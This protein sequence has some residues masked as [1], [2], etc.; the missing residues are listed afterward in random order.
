MIH[1]DDTMKET[2]VK[3]N[4]FGGKLPVLIGSFLCLL[5]TAVILAFFATGSGNVAQSGQT[6]AVDYQITK[7]YDLYMNRTISDALDGVLPIKK[8]YWLSDYDLVAPEPNQDCFGETDDPA[9][10]QWLL[11]ESQELMDGQQTLFSTDLEISPKSKVYYYLDETIMVITWKQLVDGSMYT[12]SEVKIA[13]P[14]QLR[15]FLAD[16]EYGSSKKYYPSEM[17]PAVNAVTAL[18]GDYYAF[19]DMGIV[20]Y[21]GQVYRTEGQRL[22]SCFIDTNGDMHFVHVN[23][24]NDPA[25]IEAFVKEKNIRFSLAFGPV[26]VENGE[27]C[28][29]PYYYRIG[30]ID[31]KNARAAFCQMGELHY[32]LVTVNA[33]KPAR[34]GQDVAT[35]AKYM[36]EMG[37]INAY[38]LD[39]G[40]TATLIMNDKLISFTKER[41]ISDII[42]FAT[43]IPDG[44]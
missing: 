4:I 39:G 7:R 41:M 30:E 19:R 14:S 33:E 10:L 37:C 36:H 6:S 32:L 22:D 5:W 40:Q 24:M 29:I 28:D 13:D 12:I 1:M 23:E 35:F 20:V 16:G 9:S 43:A 38:N 15:R 34:R 11:A 25:A 42:Y 31:T 21:N 18:S 8:V 26:M 27:L 17:A 44:A 2:V 3:K